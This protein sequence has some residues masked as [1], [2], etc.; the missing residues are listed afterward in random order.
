MKRLMVPT[1]YDPLSFKGDYKTKTNSL[2]KGTNKSARFILAQ[3]CFKKA[4]QGKL[5]VKL[6]RQDDA[7]KV[8]RVVRE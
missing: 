6:L 4:T 7:F 8:H 2:F 5:C 1:N 3:N